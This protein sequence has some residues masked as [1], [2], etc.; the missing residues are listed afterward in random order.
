MF[1]FNHSVAY[2]LGYS[3]IIL[4]ILRLI[5]QF[6]MV[7]TKSPSQQQGVCLLAKKD[8]RPGPAHYKDDST[9]P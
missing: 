8:L 1:D 2:P 3:V 6:F 5:D 4:N 7:F 9:P